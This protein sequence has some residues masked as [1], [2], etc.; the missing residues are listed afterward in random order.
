[1]VELDYVSDQKHLTVMNHDG[2]LNDLNLCHNKSRK[3]IVD[4]ESTVLIVNTS[5]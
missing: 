4:R 3:N 1:M 5:S 2:R